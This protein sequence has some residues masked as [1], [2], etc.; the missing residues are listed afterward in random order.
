MHRYLRAIGFSKIKSRKQLENIYHDTLSSPNRKT[1]TTIGV[2]TTLIQI[3]KNFGDEIGLSLIGE[4]DSSGSLS[5]EHY[6]PYVRPSSYMEFEDIKVEPHCDKESYA[7]IIDDINMSVIFY[8]QN[9]AD[10]AKLVWFNRRKIINSVMLSALS[11]EGTILIPINKTFTDL[12]IEKRELK[13]NLRLAQEARKGDTDAIEHLVLQDI[14]LKNNISRRTYHEDV[15]SIVDTSMIP[16]GVEC[17]Q[18]EVIGTILRVKQI[19]NTLTHEMMYNLDIKCNEY[20]I[21]VCINSL[22]LEGMPAE[23]RRFKGVIWLQ[24]FLCL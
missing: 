10:Y 22:D 12:K 19:E 23:G 20:L 8:V 13:N 2:D 3:D 16:Y 4:I 11:T 18:Y 7:G 24:G 15:L 14:D 5:I 1:A 9:I 21:N 6:F 17:E